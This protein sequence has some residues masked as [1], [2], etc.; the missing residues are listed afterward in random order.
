MR[1]IFM[2]KKRI[3]EARKHEK[4]EAKSDHTLTTSSASPEKLPRSSKMRVISSL[5]LKS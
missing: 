4:K 1:S 2:L 5:R 3:H